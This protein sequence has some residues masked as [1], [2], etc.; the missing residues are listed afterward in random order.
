MKDNAKKIMLLSY[1]PANLKP[2]SLTYEHLKLFLPHL[3]GSGLRSLIVALKRTGYL[4]V[5]RVVDVTSIRLTNRGRQEVESNF[6]FLLNQASGSGGPS[7]E[8]SVDAEIP[9]ATLIFLQSPPGDLQFR[10]LRSLLVKYRAINL[11]RGVYIYPFH[12]PSAV[13]DECS[14]RYSDAV[15]IGHLQKWLI[16]DDRQIAINHFHILDLIQS[17]SGI[18]RDI[19]RLIERKKLFRELNNQEKK[20]LS[21]LFNRWYSNIQEDY[22]LIPFYFPHVNDGRVLLKRLQAVLK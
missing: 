13:I 2:L 20:L 22:G 14:S 4:E 11:A 8:N 18:S 7:T 1:E 3:T 6:P 19:D 10:Y 21:S 16:G 5:E 12:F 15:V 17:Y 9:W